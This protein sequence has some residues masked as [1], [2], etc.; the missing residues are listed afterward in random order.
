MTH[1]GT[2]IG[3]KDFEWNRILSSTEFL[4][5]TES[6]GVNI[7]DEYKDMIKSSQWVFTF[8]ETE[9]Q[10][11][12]STVGGVL[13]LNNYSD[14]YDVG[15]LRLHFQ[16]FSGKYYD[17]GVVN[18]LTD[19]GNDPIGIGAADIKAAWEEFWDNFTLVIGLIIFL[20]ALCICLNF[21]P[22]VRS[23]LDFLIK[24]MAAAIS[25]PFRIIKWLFKK[26]GR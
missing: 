4:S 26:D 21:L 10:E 22:P 16:D 5:K 24:G 18:N 9:R 3:A 12:V 11:S 15:L 25:F 19:P 2:G 6:Q 14:V 20:V 13:H 23:L 1:V 17:L 7:P 8:L